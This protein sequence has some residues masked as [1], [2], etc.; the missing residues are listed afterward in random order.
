M[1]TKLKVIVG[2]VVVLG[3]I[4][5]FY[6]TKRW[7]NYEVGY[8]KMVTKEVKTQMCSLVKP[9]KHAEIFVDPTMCK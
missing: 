5:G 2:T 4:Y 6:Q 7:F 8:S 9:E 3:A 1:K